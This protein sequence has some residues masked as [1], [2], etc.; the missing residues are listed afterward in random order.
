[1]YSIIV[2]LTDPNDFRV[3]NHDFSPSATNCLAL[4]IEAVQKLK[5]TV[6]LQLPRAD[7]LESLILNA[8]FVDPS[9]VLVKTSKK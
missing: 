5:I 9:V 6:F 1:M 8:I 7:R 3:K 4:V 2:I